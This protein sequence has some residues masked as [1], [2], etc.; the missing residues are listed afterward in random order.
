MVLVV[1]S[2]CESMKYSTF[3]SATKSV[4]EEKYLLCV[5]YC[6]ILKQQIALFLYSRFVLS[7]FLSS[8]FNHSKTILDSFKTLLSSS[9]KSI[10]PSSNLNPNKILSCTPLSGQNSV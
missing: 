4:T 9:I 5:P 3:K 8:V 6:F 1:F 2:S 10:F 7:R